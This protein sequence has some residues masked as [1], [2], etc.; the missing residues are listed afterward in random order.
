MYDIFLERYKPNTITPL[1]IKPVV[2][3]QT[4][5]NVNK[6]ITYHKSLPATVSNDHILVELIKTLPLNVNLSDY[7]Y[8]KRALVYARYIERLMGFSSSLYRGSARSDIFYQDSKYEWIISVTEPI[9]LY[10]VMGEWTNM[11]PI[12]VL[13][14]TLTDTMIPTYGGQIV[15][16]DKGLITLS[17]DIPLLL[18]QYKAYC[19][20]VSGGSVVEFIH[21]YVL[22]NIFYSHIDLVIFNRIY[23]LFMGL[24]MDKSASH[25]NGYPFGLTD[26]STRIDDGLNIALNWIVGKSQ[27]YATSLYYIPTVYSDNLD[28]SLIVPNLTQTG[29]IKWLLYLTRLR[30]MGFLISVGA[31]GGVSYNRGLINKLQYDL[32]NNMPS[33][34][35]MAKIYTPIINNILKL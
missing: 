25:G 29:S 27:L 13:E 22:P 24:P 31:G 26:Y 32:K 30:A 8:Y 9:L 17:I 12:R 1:T 6:I 16:Y 19:N 18:L 15:G 7:D 4:R 20:S 11:C 5:N 21:R 3:T 2:L 10:T 33:D 23:S 14:H 34:S 35:T 28:Y